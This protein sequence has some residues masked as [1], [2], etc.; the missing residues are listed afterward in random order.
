MKSLRNLSR[1]LFNR[2]QYGFK[3]YL[4]GFNPDFKL[5][6]NMAYILHQA[7]MMATHIEFDQWQ[8]GGEEKVINNKVPKSTDEQKLSI[9]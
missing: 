3:S 4:I 8:H 2:I 7:D 1:I 5:R 6:T 9:K